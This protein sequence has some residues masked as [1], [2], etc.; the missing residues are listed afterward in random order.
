[1][2]NT[3]E[4]IEYQ[5]VKSHT[6]RG[7]RVNRNAWDDARGCY[8]GWFRATGLLFST[9]PEAQRWIDETANADH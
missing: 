2:T 4:T 7:Y 3:K 5:I 1:M 8:G 6:R 9:R